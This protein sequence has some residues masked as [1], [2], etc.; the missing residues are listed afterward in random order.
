[1]QVSCTTFGAEALDGSPARV[2]N[3]R[4]AEC[5]QINQDI[6]VSEL[7]CEAT[8]AEDM[9]ERNEIC[10]EEQACMRST[11][12]FSAETPAP[13]VHSSGSLSMPHNNAHELGALQFERKW[14]HINPGEDDTSDLNLVEKGDPKAGKQWWQSPHGM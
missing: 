6:S 7:G 11:N 14:G 13:D 2:P 8:A 12:V 9:L 3:L 10:S 5:S 1:M 4:V